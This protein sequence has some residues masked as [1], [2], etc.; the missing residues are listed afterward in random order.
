MIDGLDLLA[1]NRRRQAKKASVIKSETISKCVDFVLKQMNMEIFVFKVTRFFLIW[2]WFGAYSIP[3]CQVMGQ[4]DDSKCMMPMCVPHNA[5]KHGCDH[6]DSAN[7]TW[8]HL[9]K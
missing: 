7:R 2:F 6:L 5:A 1:I 3:S 8:I 9:T 4:C